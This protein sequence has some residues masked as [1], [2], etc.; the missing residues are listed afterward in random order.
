MSAAPGRVP[1]IS[2][3]R[4]VA[5]GEK[6]A[7][8][9]RWWYV[10]FRRLSIYVTWALLHTKVT[11]NQVTIASLVAAT[12]G[13]VMVGA[14][15]PWLAVA[16]YLL[17]LIYHLLDR[18]DGEIARV[19]ETYSLYGIYLDNAGH[20]FTGAGVIIATTFRLTPTA[21]QPQ[22]LWLLGVCGAMASIMSRVEKHASFHLFS[23]YVTKR[24]A[25]AR[26]L[27]GPALEGALTRSAARSFRSEEGDTRR[28]SVVEFA[29]DAALAL[30]AFPS[31][32]A[33]LLLGVF[34]EIG[35]GETTAAIWALVLVCTLQ[36][37][38]YVALEIAM[39]TQSLASETLRLLDEYEKLTGP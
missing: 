32:V 2:K 5:Q 39:L 33:I 8:D 12:V 27:G 16:G 30:T 10:I 21:D 37:L 15:T 25:L 29:R 7:G 18:V 22:V 24:P 31:V 3:L 11:A 26:A 4:P 38:A 35:W 13:I 14:T 19:R 36:I 9:R 1:P 6:V 20:Y 34:A 23:Q 17:L 28:R